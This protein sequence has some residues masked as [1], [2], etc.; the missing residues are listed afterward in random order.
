MEH[1]RHPLK[2]FTKIT[3]QN[4]LIIL[5]QHLLDS[6]EIMYNT[7]VAT[8]EQVVLYNLKLNPKIP[9]FDPP[10]TEARIHSDLMFRVG[11]PRSISIS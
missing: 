8:K 6:K 2:S 5:S 7:S 9:N 3:I 4:I 10:R 1:L 11:E